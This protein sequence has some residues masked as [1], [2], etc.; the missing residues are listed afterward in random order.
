MSSL[1][2]MWEEN[3]KLVPNVVELASNRDGTETQS[4]LTLD[5]LLEDVFEKRIFI[6]EGGIKAGH[7]GDRCD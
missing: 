3:W 5:L 2:C 4:P 7:S 6:R 1:G